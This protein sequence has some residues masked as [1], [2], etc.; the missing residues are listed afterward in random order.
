MGKIN[1]YDLLSEFKFQ[2]NYSKY[3]EIINRKETWEESVDQLE[4]VIFD[5]QWS[6]SWEPSRDSC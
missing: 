6:T 5:S 2:S 4:K 1:G 3:V